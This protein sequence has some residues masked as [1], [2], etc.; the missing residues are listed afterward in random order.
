MRVHWQEVAM[1]I[2]IVW[3]FSIVG[4]I[5]QMG[6]WPSLLAGLLLGLLAG[7]LYWLLMP[8]VIRWAAKGVKPAEEAPEENPP[9]GRREDGNSDPNDAQNARR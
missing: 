3:I 5:R 2:A 8:W 9:P 4:Q 1:V 6:F 7:A